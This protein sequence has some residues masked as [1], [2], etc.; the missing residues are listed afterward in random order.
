MVSSPTSPRLASSPAITSRAMAPAA[1]SRPAAFP[2][3]S[4]SYGA[5]YGSR[6]RAALPAAGLSTSP[7][8][9]PTRQVSTA[10]RKVIEGT[11][12]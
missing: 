12:L 7:R 6:S 8:S 11:V 1:T 5:G 2:S 9:I 4:V 10:T 3:R